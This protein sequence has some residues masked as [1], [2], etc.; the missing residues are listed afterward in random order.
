MEYLGASAWIAMLLVFH[1]F[2][3][4]DRDRLWAR[5]RCIAAAVSYF[6]GLCAITDL[7]SRAVYFGAQCD[8]TS[9]EYFDWR[10]KNGLNWGAF[11][12]RLWVVCC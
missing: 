9:R 7:L 5:G 11:R 2:L 3:C 4:A 1:G 12:D 6:A 10:L 8:E